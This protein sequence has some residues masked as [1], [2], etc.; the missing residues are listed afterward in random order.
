ML[1]VKDDI[2]RDFEEA[3]E[4]VEFPWRETQKK[5]IFGETQKFDIPLEEDHFMLLGVMCE[6]LIQRKTNQKQLFED[7]L[8][9]TKPENV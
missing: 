5:I 2:S 3:R 8:E 9:A 4:I 7:L 1:Q 6:L